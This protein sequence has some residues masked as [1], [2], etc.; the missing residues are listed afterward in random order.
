MNNTRPDDADFRATGRVSAYD[1]ETAATP[2]GGGELRR[3]TAAARIA[4][5]IGVS[6]VALVVVPALVYPFFRLANSIAGERLIGYSVIG[7]VAMLVATVV[8]VRL[9]R[10]R[11]SETTRLGADALGAWPVVGGFSA[12][13]F[14]I[15]VP[16]GLLIWLGVLHVVPAEPGSWG[17]G[18]LLAFAILVPAALTEELALRG[19]AFTLML[20]AWGPATAIG[21][22]SVAFG[23]LHVFNPGVTLQSVAMVT[24]A[25]VFLALVRVAFNSLWAAWLAHLAYNFVQAAVF[26]TTV[27]GLAIPQPNYRTVPAGPDWLTGG[28]WGPEAGAAAGGGM[29]VVSFLLAVHAG[30]VRNPLRAR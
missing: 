11:W 23:L 27:S 3:L 24:L 15:T 8:T 14:A 28:A 13:W 25:G 21:V 10:E 2:A 5:F 30:W 20:R 16:I 4:A 18:A 9:F 6:L 26:H 19:Y 22:T 12:G 29:L 7:C 1:A 17:Q